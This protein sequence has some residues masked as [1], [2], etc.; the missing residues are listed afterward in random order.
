MS[1]TLGGF[2]FIKDPIKWDYC[3]LE[4]VGSLLEFCD[5]VVVLDAGSTDG[6]K[7]ILEDWSFRSNKLKAVFYQESAWLDHHGKEKLAFF[8]N[9]CIPWLRTDYQFLLQAD[10]IVHEDSYQWIRRAMESDAEGVL[11]SRFN[12]WG[13][14]YTKLVVPGNR[15]PCSPQVIRLTKTGYNTYGDGEN[16]GAQAI[17]NFVE[18]IRIY[19]MGFVRKREVMK[20][21][22][23]N[24]QRDVFEITPDSKLDGMDIFNPWAWFD[25]A[26]V[27]PICESLPRIVQKWS[28]DREY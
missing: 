7:E 3:W 26:D 18:Q 10:E 6:A 11:C 14:P 22:I 12:L 4:A 24:M 1:K 17:N 27:A 16:I 20:G 15:M 25:L 19:H 2:M 8:Q 28:M 9:E 13:S 21:K 5:K 23:I